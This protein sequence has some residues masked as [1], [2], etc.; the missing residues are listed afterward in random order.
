MLLNFQA[1]LEAL[2]RGPA[3]HGVIG[4][5][6]QDKRDI[7]RLHSVDPCLIPGIDSNLGRSRNGSALPKTCRGTQ[8]A[9]DE[10]K[11]G[12]HFFVSP[13][14]AKGRNVRGGNRPW[15]NSEAMV[16]DRQRVRQ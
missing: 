11:E 3:V 2:S 16:L 1:S 7:A 13:C 4:I 14:S 8:N 9:R 15:L 6:R 10:Q 12:S 5:S